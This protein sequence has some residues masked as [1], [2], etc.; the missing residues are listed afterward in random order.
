MPVVSARDGK[1]NKTRELE[2]TKAPSAGFPKGPISGPASTPL[3]SLCI[4]LMKLGK[5]LSVRR[6]SEYFK[7]SVSGIFYIIIQGSKSSKVK[8]Q[9]KKKGDKRKISEQSVLSTVAAKWRRKE[10]PA[11]RI[12]QP[13]PGDS[14]YGRVKHQGA[15]VSRSFQFPTV[16]TTRLRPTQRRRPASR[17]VARLLETSSCQRECSLLARSQSFP[18]ITR[19]IAK[20]SGSHDS[21]RKGEGAPRQEAS[22]AR[23]RAVIRGEKLFALA[24]RSLAEAL[25]PR[26]AP[27]RHTQADVQGL[28]DERIGADKPGTSETASLRWGGKTLSSEA[29]DGLKSTSSSRSPF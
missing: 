7:D 23:K 18:R 9:K 20:D 13:T 14:L 10:L 29:Y 28:R 4:G 16:D 19:I 12:S 24:K 3:E 6:H 1:Y 27:P 26:S 22:F 17:A 2:T 25:R 21:S 8:R 5:V 15:F 11:A